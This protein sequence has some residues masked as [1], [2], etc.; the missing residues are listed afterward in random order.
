MPE[1]LNDTAARKTEND[2]YMADKTAPR[3]KPYSRKQA[4]ANTV[5]RGRTRLY[6][7]EGD[8]AGHVFEGH[9]VE[10]AL[11]EGWADEPYIHPNNPDHVPSNDQEEGPELDQN[12]EMKVLWAEV[13]R[14]KINPRPHPRTGKEKL[15][16]V[17]EAA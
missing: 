13:D 2:A 8:P 10:G 9:E 14:L 7:K 1:N 17:I 16:K 12:D 15:M 3:G 6:L 4:E 11:G 5:H